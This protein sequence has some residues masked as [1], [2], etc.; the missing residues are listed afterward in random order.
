[1][2]TGKPHSK[3]RA[4]SNTTAL[5]SLPSNL[6]AQNYWRYSQPKRKNVADSMAA[7][8]KVARYAFPMSTWCQ[9][10]NQLMCCVRKC[11]LPMKVEP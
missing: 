1:M 9:L 10:Q 4:R 7:K 5:S 3:M 11:R 6:D 2:H 8:M